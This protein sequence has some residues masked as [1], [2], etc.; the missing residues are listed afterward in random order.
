MY[1]YGYRYYHYNF[2][3]WLSR[4]PIGEL[5]S[6]NLFCFVVNNPTYWV[7]PLGAAITLAQCES[8]KNAALNH[9]AKTKRLMRVLREHHCHIPQ[10]TCAR[11]RDCGFFEP[12]TRD[13]TICLD[14]NDTPRD[15]IE[16]IAHE[17]LH[18]YDDC[19]GTDWNNCEDRACSE[20]R[21]VDYDGGCRPGGLYYN[22]TESYKDCI[23]R[24]AAASTATAP[25]CGDGTA[26]VNAVF[27]RCFY[28]E[29]P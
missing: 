21:A 25:S 8:A 4:D 22:S 5:D 10:I 12:R 26:A 13:I 14:N 23:K 16:T 28:G 3:R 2:G 11:C 27:R 15:V 18:A 7:D 20:I 9:N 24:V 29:K 1:Y 17:L 19:I 6:A